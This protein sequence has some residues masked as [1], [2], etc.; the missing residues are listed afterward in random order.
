MK[1]IEIEEVHNRLLAIAKVFDE[2]C[3]RHN[4]SYY[5]LGG[6]M[7]GAI[8]HKGF[9]PWDDDMD[10][11]VL[12]TEYDTLLSIL[13]KE[14]PSNFRCCTYKN[15]PAIQHAFCKIED[16]ETCI[17]DPRVPL[18]LNEQC[19]INIDV[20]PLDYCD[21]NSRIV[22]K[23]HFLDR[24]STIVYVE[25]STGSRLKATIKNLLRK[26][27]P[28]SLRALLEKQESVAKNLKE[29]SSLGNIYGRWK[30]REIIPLS[31]YGQNCR[32]QFENIM[33]NGIAEY[34]KYLT[35]LYGDYMRLPP[36]EKCVAHVNN[37]Y[38][39]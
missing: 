2:I 26:M 27:F 21:T 32:Y 15:H 25:S 5:M 36:K 28:I 13:E 11:G 10:F 33:L 14:L 35:R 20:F 30:E 34:D 7:L 39:K 38:V 4:I 16:C 18:S 22:K 17:L 31:W 9:I 24:L 37:I 1:K 23:I 8:R 3:L 12:R 29:G 19:G 6:T